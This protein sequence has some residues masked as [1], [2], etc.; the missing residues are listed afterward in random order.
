MR[1]PPLWKTHFVPPFY[2]SAHT[3]SAKSYGK[4]SSMHVGRFLFVSHVD[5]KALQQLNVMQ[6]LSKVKAQVT[7][8]G[9]HTSS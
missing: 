5:C 9:K 8:I 6:G 7:T 3:I 2:E 4:P 1:K